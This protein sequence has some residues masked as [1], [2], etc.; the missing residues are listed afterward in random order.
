MDNENLQ[1]QEQELI[2]NAKIKARNILLDAKED[3]TKII[4]EL[5]LLNNTDLKQAD[6]LRNDLN[7][8]IKDIN[9]SNNDSTSD[10]KSNLDI[11]DIKPNLEVFVKSL[12]KNRNYNF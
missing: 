10:K 9:I 8:K 1:R 11:K 3:A 12:G 2:N 4:K 7:S 5:T 6:K